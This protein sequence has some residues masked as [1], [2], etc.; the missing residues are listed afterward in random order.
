MSD[1]AYTTALKNTL[2][3]IQHICPDVNCSFIFTGDGKIV[4]GNSEA[5]E[6][7]IEKTM[8]SFQ[9]LAK[10]M[11]E[12]G[13]LEAFS[14]DGKTGKVYFSR[15][16]EIYLALAAS[17]WA[18]M[19]Y[20]QSFARVIIPTILKLLESVAPT[21]LPFVPSKEFVVETLS[22]FFLGDSVQIDVDTLASWSEILNKKFVNEVHIEASGGKAAKCRVKGM[23]EPELKGKRIIKIPEKVCKKIGVKK[24]ELVTVKPTE[25]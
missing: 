23:N 21:P 20:V 13:D 14:I 4:A 18:D 1:D 24:G 25:I 12:F 22:G 10:K 5:N 11:G 7:T 3:E 6:E 2:A 17:E 8:L 16:N 15:V 9:N 19:A